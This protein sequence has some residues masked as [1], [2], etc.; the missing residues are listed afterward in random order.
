MAIAIIG[1]SCQ[2][3]SQEKWTK[4]MEIRT[5]HGGGKV[6][7][8]ETVII[9]DLSGCYIHW[10]QHKKDT[11]SFSLSKLELNELMKEIN[12]HQFRKIISLETGNV[13]YDKPT[14][15][16][17]FKWENKTHEVRVGATEDVKDGNAE[18]FYKLYKYVLSLAVKKT[19]HTT[20]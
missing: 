2:S 20:E 19:G 16:V 3:K 11:F 18:D 14:T 4:D 13:A 6:P 5:Y 8:S 12:T 7:E 15:S 17:E 1:I 9:K 10:K